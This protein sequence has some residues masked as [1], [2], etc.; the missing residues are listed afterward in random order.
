MPCRAASV[1]AAAPA[2]QGTRTVEGRVGAERAED[3]ALM[4]AR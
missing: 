2:G 3:G 4:V 1:R